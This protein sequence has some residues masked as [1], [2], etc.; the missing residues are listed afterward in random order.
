MVG[1][2]DSR[3]EWQVSALDRARVCH[4]VGR[5]EPGLG[6]VLP[7]HQY[8]GPVVSPGEGMAHQLLGITSSDPRPENLCEGK[9]E[10]I[11]IAEDR[12]YD[13]SCVHQQ[14]GGDGIQGVG[15]PNP[16]SL[17]V[18]FR[19]EYSHPSTIPTRS[20]ELHSRLRVQIH[21]GSLRL[22]AGSSYLSENRQEI[23][24]TG[25]GPICLQTDLSVPSLLQLAARSIG[26]SDQ[27]LPAGLDDS[28]GF[29]QPSMDP[30]STG[31][32]KDSASGGTCN[33]SGPSLED[34]AMV[35]S[36]SVNVGGL[37]A[38]LTQAGGGN[39][40]N[41]NVTK[42]G[43]LERLRERYSGQGLSEQ[44]TKLILSSWR[45]KTNK[46]YDSL[47]GRWDRW[48]SERGSDPFSGPVSEVANFLASLFQEGYQY[49]SVNAYRSA[50][51]SVHEKIDGLPVG[52]HPT[53]TRLVKGLFNVRPPLPRYSSTWDVQRVLNYLDFQ[54]QSE[55]LP[56]KALT[57]KTVFLLAIT[58]PSRSA[59][60]SQ[61][62]V[63]R[64]RADT[65]GIAF[66][67]SS[68]A[69]QS[70]QGRPI[71]S[72]Y[73][74]AFQANSILCPVATLHTYLN[75]TKQLRGSEVKLFISFI[76]PHKSV[77]SSTIARWLRTTL[78]QAGIDSSVFG[79]HST[80][81]ASASAAAKG[82]V[83]LEDILKAANWSSESVFQRFYH[84]EVDRT[85]YGRAVIDQNSSM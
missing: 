30:G 59:D 56:L 21:E 51:S 39:R 50:I 6:S 34:T 20:D 23:R 45:A 63:T 8:R 67:P 53:I 82:G 29:R 18:V 15:I 61:L 35:P 85:A 71:A 13:C 41:I 14:P 81:G 19:E 79:A 4:R 62:D 43:R 16:R 10:C 17:D 22:E 9:E 37:A 26:R 70:R 76:K 49:N 77:T 3:V 12:Q 32:D 55:S 64:M 57:L 69:K 78:E 36:A 73:F 40:V 2:P 65:N 24:P 44:A 33:F 25:S 31:T 60:L 80:R 11:G 75:S 84:K 47:F 72:F 68:L 27:C 38:P 1:R 54:G 42:T 66:L 74:P 83:T 58:R 48:C 46:S 5:L 52:Q 28:E 7:G